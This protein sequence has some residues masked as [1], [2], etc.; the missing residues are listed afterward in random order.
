AVDRRRAMTTAVLA[1]FFI[2]ILYLN[3]WDGKVPAYSL[4]L[5]WPRFGIVLG[6]ITWANLVGWSWWLGK[7]VLSSRREPSPA[8]SDEA[9]SAS[10]GRGQPGHEVG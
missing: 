8:V 5:P 3:F 4:M 10:L 1:G 9:W 6:A 2:G 7:S